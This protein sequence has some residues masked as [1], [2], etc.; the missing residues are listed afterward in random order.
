[1]I[2]PFRFKIKFKIFS[3]IFRNKVLNNLNLTHLKVS[4]S[5]RLV[6]VQY[7]LLEL[8]SIKMLSFQMI[9]KNS[10]FTKS[11]IMELYNEIYNQVIPIQIYICLLWRAPYTTNKKGNLQHQ[12]ISLKYSHKLQIPS[13]NI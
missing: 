1:M 4:K 10:Q 6:K 5:I 8:I 9:L 3:Q 7:L 11:L 2:N 13:S 12:I